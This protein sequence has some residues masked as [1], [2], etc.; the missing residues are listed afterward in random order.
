M[1]AVFM[2][3]ALSLAACSGVNTG[4]SLRHPSPPEATIGLG[5][6]SLSGMTRGACI[7]KKSTETRP[8]TKRLS[9]RVFH[10]RSKEELLHEIGFAGSLSFGLSAFGIDL[11][12]DTLDRNAQTASTSF[13][14][15]QIHLEA[16][17][18]ILEGLLRREGPDA[19]YE[20][21]GDGFHFGDRARRYV[22]RHHRP[23]GRVL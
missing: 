21:C 8:G 18:Q 5:F 17:T 23:R 3:S 19:F 2:A 12:F 13:A 14:V 4:Q 7:V 15:V 9:E 6:D 22:S 20:K 1:R 10:A 11:G 16:Q